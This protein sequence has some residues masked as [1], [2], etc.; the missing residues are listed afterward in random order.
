MTH[1]EIRERVLTR[2]EVSPTD[3]AWKSAATSAINE[4]QRLFAFLTL[5]LEAQ[6][7]LVL[8][9]GTKFYRML[10]EGWTDWL[11]PLRV[12]LSNDATAGVT[13][14]FDGVQGDEG[15]FNEQAYSGL[16][17]S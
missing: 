15:M 8:T 7:P 17:M 10:A 11:V 13:A 3:A 14:R 9:P 2:L 16:T 1:A 6:R 4:G 5:S 12:R